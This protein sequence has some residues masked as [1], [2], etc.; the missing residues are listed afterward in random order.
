MADLLIDG[1]WI[2]ESISG[3]C[4]FEENYKKWSSKDTQLI[5]SFLSAIRSFSREA[6][7]ED[8]EFIQFK[9]R[10]I[11]FEVSGK[12][13]FV[14][15]VTNKSD[16]SEKEIKMVVKNIIRRFNSRFDFI[17]RRDGLLR[18]FRLLN[19]F[20]EDLREIVDREP[21]KIKLLMEEQ[22]ERLYKKRSDRRARRLEE[23]K[24][25]IEL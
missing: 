22:V 1:L 3:S 14:I 12:V 4:L 19:V 13:L 17:I 8:I 10:K 20:S 6:F 23:M 9:N 11:L 2:I 7:S 5:A 21:V 18:E 15:A 16:A 25:C 24:R